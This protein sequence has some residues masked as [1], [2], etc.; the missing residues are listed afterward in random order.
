M[1]LDEKP[2]I[3]RDMVA[4]YL[5]KLFNKK[6]RLTSFRE[7]GTGILGV[8]YL[9]GLKVG[10]EEKRLVLKT[11][12]TKGFGQDFSADRANTLL[13]ANSVYNKLPN[14]VRSYDV[15][16]IMDDG[17]L[18]SVG[19]AEEFFITMDFVEG[20]PYAE[21]LDRIKETGKLTG[22]DM[23]QV[24]ILAEYEA[25]IHSIKRIDPVLYVRRIRDL[26]GRGDCITGLIDTYPKNE[27]TYA[28]TSDEEFEKIEEKCIAWRWRIK[29]KT[30]RLCQVHGDIHPFNILWQGP[31]KFI[32]LDRSRGEWGEAADDV[33]CLS[34]NY[35][36]WSLMYCNS[37]CEPFKS[38]F[39][40]FVEK[41]LD[42]TGD[43]ELFK[44]IQP[45]YAF[46]ALVIAHPL[47]YPNIS[48]ENRRRIFD[49]MNA[50][51]DVEEF[52]YRE[53]SSYI[54]G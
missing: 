15:G 52:D 43:M 8:A 31:H 23:E 22:L 37:F 33:S 14:H 2:T 21:N 51:L 32:L 11:L 3:D 13:Y 42:L 6:V 29:D 38:L 20:A 1:S 54:K 16:A 50:V 44:V 26:I 27:R 53:V 48:V 7:L 19:G 24:R 28:F 30:H 25:K 17:S 45:F 12:S 18:I 41:Y 34:F 10:G 35:L 39:E 4:E 49:F 46:R 40:A 9:M 5:S 47:F 36:F